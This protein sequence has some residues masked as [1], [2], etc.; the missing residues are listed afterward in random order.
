MN[1]KK[2]KYVE[3]LCVKNNKMKRKNCV[4][5]NMQGFKA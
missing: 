3:Y 4:K 1:G 5:F 2:V